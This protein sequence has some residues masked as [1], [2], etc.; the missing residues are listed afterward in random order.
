MVLVGI[1]GITVLI[2]TLIDAAIVATAVI[3]IFVVARSLV[4]V[5]EEHEEEIGDMLDLPEARGPIRIPGLGAAGVGSSIGIHL[6]EDFNSGG[7]LDS[8][9][10]RADDISKENSEKNKA[11]TKGETNSRGT[12]IEQP[13]EKQN[14]DGQSNGKGPKNGSSDAFDKEGNLKQRRYYDDEGNPQKDI[15]YTDHGNPKNHE[16]PHDHYWGQNENGT[17]IRYT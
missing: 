6:V 10:N 13:N 16:K 14:P 7:E 3:A 1:V 2:E 12:H 15:D 5:F 9:D 4:D 8:S 11:K 17:N